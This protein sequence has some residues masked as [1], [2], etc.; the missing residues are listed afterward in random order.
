MGVFNTFYKTE[1]INF[2]QQGL[3]DK[4]YSVRLS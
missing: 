1:L 4:V 2:E 3:Y